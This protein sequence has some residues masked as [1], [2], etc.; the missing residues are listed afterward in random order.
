MVFD[1][2]SLLT[3]LHFVFYSLPVKEKSL[4]WFLPPA[5]LISEI[6]DTQELEE[7]IESYKLLSKLSCF[8]WSQTHV[9]YVS[10]KKNLLMYWS[11]NSFFACA[12]NL[13]V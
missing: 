13:K 12:S 11:I 2:L 3:Y 1:S 5:P 10:I 8:L 9:V 4:D 6:P 7:E